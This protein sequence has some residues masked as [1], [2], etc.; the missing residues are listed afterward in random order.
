MI[1]KDLGSFPVHTVHPDRV[2]FRIHKA[3]NDPLHFGVSGDERF[4]LRSESGAGTCYCAL[5]QVG[6]FLETFAR[7]KFLT[8]EL[9]DERVLSSLSLTRPLRLA[10]ITDK[11]VVG[12]FGITGEI[13]TGSDYVPSQQWAERFHK[14]GFDGVYYTTR[15]DPSF[16][17]R[18]VAVFG[19]E[20]G[21]AKLF[22]VVTESIPDEL[23]R[24]VCAEFGF[25]VWPSAPLA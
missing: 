5:S 6:A 7:L 16:T 18:S 15:H 10:D 23:I 8:Q 13:S 3:T 4:D 12:A 1:D 17:E 21:G 14:S 25:T 22:D 24:E 19:N 20:D 11:S 9:I 2:L